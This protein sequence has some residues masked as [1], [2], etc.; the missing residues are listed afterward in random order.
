[1]FNVEQDKNNPILHPY[2]ENK[3]ESVAACNGCPVKKGKDNYIVYR[4]IGNPDIVKAPTLHKSTI[5]I[6]KETSKNNYSDRCQL[7]TPQEN[8][9]DYGCEDPR[10]TKFGKNYYIFY[11]AISS[12]NLGADSIRSAV[13]VTDDLKNI[14]E[15]HLVTPFNSKAATLFPEKI[16]GKYTMILTVDTDNPPVKVCIAQ[17]D[18]IED[19]WDHKKWSEWYKNIDKHTVNLKREDTDLTEVGAT[20]I[21]TKDGW[22]LIYSHIQN[23]FTEFERIFGVE[24]VL[25]DS[26]KPTKILGRT[27]FPI[28]VPD[29]LYT[30]YGFVSNVSFP[31][32][33]SINGDELTIYYG[34][35]DTTT[36]KATTKLSL[37]LRELNKKTKNKLFKR[38]SGNPVLKPTKK[39]WENLNVMNPAAIDIEGVVRILYRAQ[40]KDNTSV[41]GYAESKN[42]KTINYRHDKPCYV[43]RIK[44]ELKINEGSFSGCED[45][46]L[47][48]IG[49]KIYMCYTAYNGVEVP[50]IA[51]SSIK[52]EDLAD[53]KFNWS[54]PVVISPGGYDDKDSCVLPKKF[55]DGY[56]MIHRISGHITGDYVNDL[57]FTKNEIDTSVE[58]L[59]PRK[60]MWDGLKV[61]LASTPHLVKEG[62]L[63]FYHGVS[64]DK[65]Y[66]VGA[67]LLDKNDPEKIIGR[68]ALPILEPETT[69]EK[70]GEV[71]NVVFPCGTVIRDDTV[72]MYYGC[73]DRRVGIATG[74]LKSIL[75]GLK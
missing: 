65:V 54:N 64:H 62:W 26:K 74:S 57:Y 18:K 14:K 63:M 19:I 21:K 67:V 5:A 34:A 8:W 45:P 66:R 3:W 32:G 16:N 39:A 31:T 1:M 60:G 68:S 15:R 48:L 51:I 17:F 10:V 43:P 2:R 50:K 4:A 69:Y 42:G 52:K 35:A 29:Q 58:I 71:N 38:V 23:Y 36:C 49:D 20:P 13:A 59:A 24:A 47:T 28:L 44:D 56:F 6:A 37:L 27:D 30:K 75:E 12:E 53:R 33:S 70:V 55:R 41:I 7:V 9:D 61:G 22:L 73:A 40:S 11:T 72:F 46:R 25:L